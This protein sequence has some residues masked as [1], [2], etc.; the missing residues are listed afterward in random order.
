[1]SLFIF[2]DFRHGRE[3]FQLLVAKNNRKGAQQGSLHQIFI[4]KGFV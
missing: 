4:S 3:I 2:V 1:M